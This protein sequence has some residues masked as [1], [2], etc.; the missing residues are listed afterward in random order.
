MASG[1]P[2]E[3]RSLL[4]AA[5]G[6]GADGGADGDGP[7][8]SGRDADGGAACFPCALRR[9]RRG[10]RAQAA[11]STLG[12]A[13]IV[14]YEVSGGPFGS[15]DAVSAGGPLLALLGFIVMPLVWSVPEAFV[16]AELATAMPENAGYAA[17]VAEAFGPFWG[18]QEGYWSWVS[19]VTDNA[20]YPLLFLL[21]LCGDCDSGTDDGRG[22][23]RLGDYN[24]FVAALLNEPVLRVL[25]L[26]ATIV[27]LTLI[28]YRGI[29]IVGRTSVVLAG[30]TLLPFVIMVV[31]GIPRVRQR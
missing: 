21:Y 15:E 4:R 11:L 20:V 14:F 7:S 24:H 18:F 27:L 22:G 5:A 23:A 6:G 16:V 28:N 1:A 10:G 12:L 17:W 9:R 2:D 13:A 29:H 8:S 30:F 26:A 31:L 19:G 25:F 3:Q